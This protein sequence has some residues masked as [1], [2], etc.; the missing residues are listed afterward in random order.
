MATTVLIARQTAA[1]DSADVPVTLAS[2][3]KTFGLFITSPLMAERGCV[4]VWIKDAGVGYTHLVDQEG[5]YVMLTQDQRNYTI[6]W[7]G[8]Y[9]LRKSATTNPIGVYVDDGT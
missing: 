9:Q 1:A 3:P 5:K 4:S 7:P 6:R 2:G 8:V